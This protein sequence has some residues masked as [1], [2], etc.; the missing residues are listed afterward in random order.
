ME[1]RTGSVGR[2]IA[3]RFDH[4]EDFL[5]ELRKIILTEK[6]ESGWFQ[7]IGAFAQAGVVTGPKEP[8]V[9]PDPVWRQVDAVCEV[10]GSGSVHLDNGE[11]KIHLHAALGDHGETLTACIRRNTKVYLTLEL[12]LFELNGLGASRPWDEQGGFSKLRF[13]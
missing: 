2:V 12:L 8:V 1:Y 3:A 9:P 10:V 7:I 11:P 13:K 4:G 5:A 6:I